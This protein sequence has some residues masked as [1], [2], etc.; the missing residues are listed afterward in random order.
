M[1][2]HKTDSAYLEQEELRQQTRAAIAGKYEV[3]K[4]ISCLPGP[5]YKV[6]SPYDGISDAAL[7]QGRRCNQQN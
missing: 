1:S 3:L 5:Q 6:F 2:L 4:I 7:A